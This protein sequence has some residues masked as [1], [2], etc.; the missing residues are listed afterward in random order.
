M[1]LPTAI[2]VLV[3]PVLWLAA[4]VYGQPAPADSVLQWQAPTACPD[5]SQVE[6]Q[7]VD[8]LGRP[9]EGDA[10][11]LSASATI[12]ARDGLF[13]LRLVTRSAE[14]SGARELSSRDC[15][16]LASATA[17]IL[18]LTIDPDIVDAAELEA[19]ATPEPQPQ[20]DSVPDA[21]ARAPQTVTGANEDDDSSIA[22]GT[23]ARVGA[24][25]DVGALPSG[26]IGPQLEV[27]LSLD[28]LEVLARG[29]FLPPQDVDGIARSG[30]VGNL[31]LAAGGPVLCYALTSGRPRL[32]PCVGLAYG[33]VW[34]QGEDITE[35]Q[36]GTARWLEAELRLRAEL[37]LTPWLALGAGLGGALPLIRTAF[38]VEGHGEVHAPATLSARVGFGLTVRP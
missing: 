35:G 25:A 24:L 15:T 33:A 5:Q 26:G 29:L 13:H 31:R 7:L 16:E 1:R 11:Q 10:A 21:A 9:L 12:E 14:G 37:N 19:L 27:G 30:T 18:A 17:L 2:P 6:S 4:P 28:R 38:R 34:G 20:P 36:D 3:V 8:R 23:V 32:L 22:V